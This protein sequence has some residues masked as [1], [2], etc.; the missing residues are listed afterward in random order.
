MVVGLDSR[1][2]DELRVLS[3]RWGKRLR[4][5]WWAWASPQPAIILQKN[6]KAI[7]TKGDRPDFRDLGIGT[8]GEE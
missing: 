4:G 7:N 3:A 1:G 8:G 5:S 2:R 6:N